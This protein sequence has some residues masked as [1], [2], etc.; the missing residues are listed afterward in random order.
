MLLAALASA[1]LLGPGTDRPGYGPAAEETAV[2][3]AAADETAETRPA[4]PD[5]S[6]ARPSASEAPAARPSVS[7][8]SA[9]QPAAPQPAAAE[10]SAPETAGAAS[11]EPNPVVEERLE[12]ES[13]L[14]PRD[15]PARLLREHL[16]ISGI[17]IDTEGIRRTLESLNRKSELAQFTP[18]GLA[19]APYLLQRAFDLDPS[20]MLQFR[21]SGRTGKLVFRFTWR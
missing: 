18:E 7:E 10:P 9:A 14:F 3:R 19:I 15:P 5:T 12:L 20:T 16:R 2:D 13:L 6:A 1:L 4:A 11:L 8:T 21:F 17:D